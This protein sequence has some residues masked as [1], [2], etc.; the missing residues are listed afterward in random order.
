M[1][2]EGKVEKGEN[3]RKEKDEIKDDNKW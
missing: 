2:S 3:N 1:D